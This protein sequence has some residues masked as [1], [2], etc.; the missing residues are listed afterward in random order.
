MNT[1]TRGNLLDAG[2]TAGEGWDLHLNGQ[3]WVEKPSENGNGWYL[4]DCSDTDNLV[5]VLRED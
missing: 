3:V 4:G 1:Q 2:A 5:Y